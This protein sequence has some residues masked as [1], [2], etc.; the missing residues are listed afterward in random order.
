M[1]APAQR[2]TGA[3]SPGIKRPGREADH[4]PPSRAEAENAWSYTTIPTYIFR[5]WCLCTG[6]TLLFKC[7][8]TVHITK[9]MDIIYTDHYVVS[10]IIKYTRYLWNN[11][12]QWIVTKYSTFLLSL[13]SI[14]SQSNYLPHIKTWKCYVLLF[15]QTRET[16]DYQHSN[17]SM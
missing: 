5:S 10:L 14:L 9:L 8:Q 4:W 2:V 7:I 3:P 13:P 1:K 11:F 6:T 16:L 17:H 12:L 15:T